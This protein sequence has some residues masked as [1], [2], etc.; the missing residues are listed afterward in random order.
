MGENKNLNN[1]MYNG[2]KLFKV[3]FERFYKILIV[4]FKFMEESY[5]TLRRPL[6]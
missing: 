3:I 4:I 1:L 2:Y 5:D 6:G